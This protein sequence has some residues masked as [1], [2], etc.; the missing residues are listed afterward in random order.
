MTL[1]KSKEELESKLNYIQKSP[2]DNGI[3]SLIVRRPDVDQREELERCVLSLK[4]GLVGDSWVKRPSSRTVDNSAHAEAQLT[5]MNTRTI[6]SICDDESR[7]KLAG[8]QFFID[9]DLSDKNLPGG[10]QLSIG[11]AIIQISSIPH[12]G[13]KKF[14]KRYGKDAVVFVNSEIG[15]KLH[16]RGVNARVIKPGMIQKG[17]NVCKIPTPR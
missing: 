15:K 13:C 17:D 1:Y 12:T 6:A 8:D 4:E 9:L 5:I 3:L 2:L 14:A 11:S 16:L 7:W 10:T